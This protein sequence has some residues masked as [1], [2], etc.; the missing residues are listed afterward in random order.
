[1]RI[2]EFDEETDVWIKLRELISEF[3]II[4]EDVNY[5]YNKFIYKNLIPNNIECSEF[6]MLLN[7]HKNLIYEI[8]T[9]E[10]TSKYNK[11]IDKE[12]KQIISDINSVLSILQQNG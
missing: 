8:F 12:L 2:Y 7:E 5:C 3:N 9:E 4:K 11:E 10:L 1:M 6:R